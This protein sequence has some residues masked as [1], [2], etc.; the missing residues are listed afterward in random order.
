MTAILSLSCGGSDAA[1]SPSVSPTP[2]A[3]RTVGAAPTATVV[4]LSPTPT[5]VP[6]AAPTPEPTPVPTPVPTAAP[7]LAPDIALHAHD[8]YFEYQGA[9]NPPITV[10]A[11]QTVV[12]EV[13]ND[14]AAIHNVQVANSDGVFGAL[15]CKPG[16]GL[17]FACSNP[18]KILAGTT[19]TLTVSFP[20]PGT[21][22]F[23]CDFHVSQMSGTFVVQ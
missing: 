5:P 20:G 14:G 3:A 17:A 7:T 2:S 19:A 23:R 12:L 8:F 11:N 16:D 4:S 15:F 21:Y 13:D 18:G 10:P 22:Q 9:R 6:T 1:P